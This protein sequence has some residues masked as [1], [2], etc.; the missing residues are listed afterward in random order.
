[1]Y[2][3]V[4]LPEA[5]NALIMVCKISFGIKPNFMIAINSYRNSTQTQQHTQKITRPRRAC[6]T[7]KIDRKLKVKYFDSRERAPFCMLL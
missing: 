4:H 5:C 1:M 7:W 6:Q 3:T 2:L